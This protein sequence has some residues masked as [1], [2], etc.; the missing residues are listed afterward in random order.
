MSTEQDAVF[1]IGRTTVTL[2]VSDVMRLRPGGR[3]LA[4][5]PATSAVSCCEGNALSRGEEALFSTDIDCLP[6]VIEHDGDRSRSADDAFDG[7]QGNRV[8]LTLGS[9]AASPRG[10]C[11]TRNEHSHCRCGLPD[12]VGDIRVQCEAQE[13]EK[14]VGGELFSRA[15]VVQNR[16]GPGLLALVNEARS[17]ATWRGDLVVD[18]VDQRSAFGVEFPGVASHAIRLTVAAECAPFATCSLSLGGILERI[19][20]DARPRFSESGAEGFGRGG[21]QRP[22]CDGCDRRT[23]SPARTEAQAS[24]CRRASATDRCASM[25]PVSPRALAAG[26]ASERRAFADSAASNDTTNI[27][28]NSGMEVFS[29][30]RNKMKRSKPKSWDNLS[31]RCLWRSRA[32]ASQF[33]AS[34]APRSRANLSCPSSMSSMTPP[35]DLR[36]SVNVL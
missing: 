16:R 32:D 12:N 24:R 10:E 35:R 31:E 1:K 34:L 11:S 28:S 8:G 2:P 29:Q 22:C 7:F 19:D 27:S 33:P 17:T 26:A 18:T 21:R 6:V 5:G 4:S 9:T 13:A 23:T 30:I 15:G 20:L 14:A 25:S 36:K 3:P